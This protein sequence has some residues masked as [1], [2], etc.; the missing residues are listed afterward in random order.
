MGYKRVLAYESEAP[1]RPVVLPKNVSI[2]DSSMQVHRPYSIMPEPFGAQD[3]LKLRPPKDR[4]ARLARA[5][6]RQLRRVN[7]GAQ[8][9]IDGFSDRKILS[10]V[11]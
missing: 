3:K 10:K 9:C 6:E 8:G 11:R 2:F 1:I 5:A 7:Q 4:G